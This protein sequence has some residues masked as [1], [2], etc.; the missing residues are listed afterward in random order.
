MV[1]GA[2][3]YL[4]SKQAVFLLF[5]AAGPVMAVWSYVDDRRTGRKDFVA[6]AAKYRGELEEISRSVEFAHGAAVT[7]RHTSHP[8]PGHDVAVA[9]GLSPDLWN[10]RP[11]HP[12]FTDLRVGL[13]SL[14]SLV[15][16]EQ[17][18]RGD[19]ELV[20]EALTIVQSVQVDPSVPVA[21]Q[22]ARRGLGGARSQPWRRVAMGQVAAPRPAV[23][24]AER[25]DR[26][27]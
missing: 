20:S 2:V 27:G 19:D 23:E 16:V 14:P 12:D 5:M 4:V 21:P 8:P 9:T 22:R 10:R 3:I 15:R 11:E 24:R 7:W 17:E 13:A 18:A 1:L 6:K 26:G 25:L